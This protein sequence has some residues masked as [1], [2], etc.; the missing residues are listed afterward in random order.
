MEQQPA[1]S[2]VP[3]VR[4]CVE[5]R[6]MSL[7]RNDR[8]RQSLLLLGLFFIVVSCAGLGS[9]YQGTQAKPD[10]RQ[11]IAE[12]KGK[13]VV[14]G[15]K[16]ISIQYTASVANE[17]L[18]MK[19]VVEPL[20]T[21]KNFPQINSLR[22]SIHFIDAGGRILATSGLWSAGARKDATL[23]RWTFA[24]QYPLPPGTSA[25]GFSY[26]GSVSDNGESG[27]KDGWDVWQ[28]P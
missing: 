7:K 11:S 25:I 24:N 22:V 16:D 13:A 23:V 2:G 26:R 19:G 12:L 3:N 17:I 1:V 5:H 15:G 10:N 18:E 8:L 27:G 20:G 14:W 21:I 6:S 28:R 4:G 9:T